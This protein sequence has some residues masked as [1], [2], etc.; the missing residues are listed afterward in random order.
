MNPL[1]IGTEKVAEEIKKLFPES[2]IIIF[3]KDHL[4]NHKKAV[5]EKDLFYNTPGA[6]VS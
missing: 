4:D 5:K 2:K 6:E 1:G 3:D